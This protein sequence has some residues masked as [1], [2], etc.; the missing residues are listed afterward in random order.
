MILYGCATG[1]PAGETILW[2]L[3]KEA[4]KFGSVLRY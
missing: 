3:A 2:V 4:G 1:P